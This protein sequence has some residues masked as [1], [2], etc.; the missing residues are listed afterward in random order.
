[1]D[2]TTIGID[3]SKAKLDVCFL[4]TGELIQLSNDNKGFGKLNKIISSSY[5]DT[6][7]I[8]IEHTGGYQQLLVEYLQSHKHHVCVVNPGN[9]RNFARACGYNAKTDK[10]DAHLLALF[11]QKMTP[12]LS[13]V[14]SGLLKELRDLVKHKKQIMDMITQEKQHLEKKPLPATVRRIEAHM[15]Y[16]KDELKEVAK[17]IEA[18]ISNDEELSLRKKLLLDVKGVGE[19]TANVLLAELPEL[20]HIDKGK[21]ASLVGLAP[22]NRDSGALRGRACIY[23][24][25][26]NVR[27]ALYMAALS[28]RRFNPILKAFYENLR[29]RGKPYKVATTAVMRKLIICINA[30]LTNINLYLDS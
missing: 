9:V 7:R 30:K 21:V 6:S 2:Y 23:G 12:A 1:M 13:M 11:G 18:V 25:R 17:D 14:N 16:L 15:A 8:V 22:F 29:N 27:N 24:G 20:G 10:I 28:A 19:E 26:K 3:V 5:Q 4:R